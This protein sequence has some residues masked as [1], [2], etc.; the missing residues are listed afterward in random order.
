VARQFRGTYAKRLYTVANSALL[1]IDEKAGQDPTIKDT[2]PQG[3]A[4]VPPRPKKTKKYKTDSDNS[5][6]L[7]K[8]TLEGWLISGP[9]YGSNEGFR[10]P[11][12]WS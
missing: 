12:S 3:L 2:R 1:L 6:V 5:F 9:S 4:D 7:S 8:F 10:T 11:A